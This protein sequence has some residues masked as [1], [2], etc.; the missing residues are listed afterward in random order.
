MSR[1]IQLHTGPWPLL[2]LLLLL[3]EKKPCPRLSG[4]PWCDRAIF[5]IAPLRFSGGCIAG[6]SLSGMVVYHGYREDNNVSVQPRRIEQDPAAT[7]AACWRSSP[8][9]PT[10]AN[11]RGEDC[12]TSQSCW[13]MKHV[14]ASANV[15]GKR[16]RVKNKVHRQHATW[17]AGFLVFIL[18]FLFKIAERQKCR[19]NRNVSPKKSQREPR[20]E[21]VR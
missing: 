21:M 13:L 5:C 14:N 3:R 9:L 16:R 11:R 18:F 12:N 8:Q 1:E 17:G 2:L 6:C 7:A 20:T 19:G 4:S 10:S 15:V